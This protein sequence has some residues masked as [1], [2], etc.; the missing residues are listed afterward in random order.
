MASGA[1]WVISTLGILT[2]SLV[3]RVPDALAQKGH[4]GGHE[5]G[6]AEEPPQ[7]A[8]EAHEHGMAHAEAE[9]AVPER[10]AVMATRAQFAFATPRESLIPGRPGMPGSYHLMINAVGQI[11]NVGLGSYTISNAGESY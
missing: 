10:M 6:A 9:H 8:E 1:F 4:G 2:L 5:H 3:A 11:Q 7:D